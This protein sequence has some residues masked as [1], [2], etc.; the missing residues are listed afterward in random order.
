LKEIRQAIVDDI[1]SKTL[2]K[3]VSLEAYVQPTQSPVSWLSFEL[4][5][6]LWIPVVMLIAAAVV[7]GIL[8]SESLARRIGARRQKAAAS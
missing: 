3:L 1:D 8:L 5:I 6:G 4:I 7:S 2:A